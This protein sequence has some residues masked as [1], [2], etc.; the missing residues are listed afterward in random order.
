MILNYMI[1]MYSMILKNVPQ[2]SKD[3]PNCDIY[4]VYTT[5]ISRFA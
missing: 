2:L 1:N 5:G 4:T 3:I